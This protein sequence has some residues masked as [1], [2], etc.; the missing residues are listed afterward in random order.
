MSEQS[1]R[2]DAFHAL[3]H[4]A[5]PF[6]VPNPW[7]VGSAR[8]LE[9]KGFQALATTSAGF[10][11]AS[12]KREGALAREEVLA[13]CADLVRAVSIPVSADLEDGYGDN[14]QSVA[15]TYRLAGAAG[16]AGA[17]IEDA[18][19]AA[20][21]PLYEAA[22]AVDRVRAA[23]EGVRS[24]PY[25]FTLTARAENYL[26]GNPDLG[27]TISRLQAYQEAGADVLYAPGLTRLDD[28][29]TLVRSVD[30]PVNVVVGLPG[31]QFSVD[32]LA[33]AG[34]KRISI[35]SAL[36]RK[37]FG[38]AM[39]AADEMLESGTFNFASTAMPFARINDLFPQGRGGQD[40]SG[41]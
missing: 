20:A 33:E 22:A 31:T 9:A 38:T 8:M 16:L 30:L 37:A 29:T 13:H 25:R 34:V 2:A 4:E 27:D 5:K 11:F 14:L 32:E 24:L 7:D 17:S 21:T 39:E 18:R 26:Y 35:G 23:V 36:F 3:H 10:V 12:G 28:I 40:G 1:R 19:I 6:I 15:E 41:G